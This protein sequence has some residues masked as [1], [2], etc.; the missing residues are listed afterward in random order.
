MLRESETLIERIPGGTSHN[1]TRLVVGPDRLLYVS[2]GDAGS[3]NKS[4]DT[5]SLAGK[6]LRLTLDGKPALGNP[7]NNEV[8]SIGHRNPQGLAFQ[9]GTG[10]L[11]SSEHS[12]N[13]D[14]EVNLIEGGRNYGWPKVRGLC[15]TGGE[16]NFCRDKKVAAPVAVFTP[17]VAPAGIAFYDR[18]MFP[19]WNGNLLV[20]ALGRTSLLRLVLTPDGRETVSVEQ[21]FHYQFGRLR[22]VLVGTDGAIYVA[23]SN[24]D[25][26]FTELGLFEGDDKIIRITP[27]N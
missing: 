6:I 24:R 13:S 21:L 9:P 2:T 1:G 11:Y 5:K 22:D 20:A 23:T 14:D 26:H 7:F 3:E 15:D 8:W 4:Q 27:D 10:A 16:R 25:G 12:A 17:T 19:D 18:K